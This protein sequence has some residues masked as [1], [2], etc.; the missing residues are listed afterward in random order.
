MINANNFNPSSPST[1][2]NAATSQSQVTASVISQVKPSPR[3]GNGPIHQ[4]QKPSPLRKDGGNIQANQSNTMKIVNQS[5][6][7]NSSKGF[8]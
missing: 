4:Q 5:G 7:P 1:Y 8:G 3:V 6:V 2:Y